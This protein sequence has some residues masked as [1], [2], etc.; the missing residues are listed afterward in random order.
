[1]RGRPVALALALAALTPAGCGGGAEPVRDDPPPPDPPGTAGDEADAD[2]SLAGTWFVME[3]DDEE[4]EVVLEL[5]RGAGTAWQPRRPEQRAQVRVGSGDHGLKEVVLLTP[6]GDRE[7]A[8]WAFQG[9]GRALL[10]ERGDDDLMLAR[11]AIPVPEA[12]RGDWIVAE[13]RGDEVLRLHLTGDHATLEMRLEEEAVGGRAWG[14]TPGDGTTADLVLEVR[15]GSRSELLV[16]RTQRITDAIYLAWENGDDDYRVVFREGQ[17]PTWIA[18]RPPPPS[19]PPP[20]AV[21]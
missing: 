1:M 6:D 21:Y 5:E 15:E 11:R 2:W 19:R 20:P 16:L 9:P 4:V 17:R 10:F 12:L 13:P 7:S 14:L 3:A 18:D 8:L